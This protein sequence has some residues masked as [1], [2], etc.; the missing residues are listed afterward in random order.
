[1][2]NGNTDDSLDFFYVGSDNISNRVQRNNSI[3][4]RYHYGQGEFST[5]VG[6][7]P[8]LLLLTR[9]IK[10]WLPHWMF[11]CII[12]IIKASS[13][14]SDVNFVSPTYLKPCSPFHDLMSFMSSSFEVFSGL[15]LSLVPWTVSLTRAVYELPGASH[16][17]S[18]NIP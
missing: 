7:S 17:I 10:R 15:P 4:G 5:Q 12:V 18:N 11:S 9:T 13:H 1:M 8:D 3:H 16:T 6:P 2:Y 14:L